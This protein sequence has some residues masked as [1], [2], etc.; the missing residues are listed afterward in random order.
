MES[1]CQ[2]GQ[3]IS[4]LHTCMVKLQ[5]TPAVA[6]SGRHSDAT[7]L[8]AVS[9]ADCTQPSSSQ[10]P[11]NRVPSANLQRPKPCRLSPCQAPEVEE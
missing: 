8:R 7:P 1:N 3:P 6:R 11:A 2:A 4:Q 10:R 5:S 9:A